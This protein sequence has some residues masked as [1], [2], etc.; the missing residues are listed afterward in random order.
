M[1]KQSGGFRIGD[2][3]RVKPGVM[4]PDFKGLSLAGWQGRVISIDEQDDDTL[5]GIQWDSVTL[6]AMPE[7]FIAQSEAEGCDCTEIGLGI[8]ELEPAQ[9]R[10]NAADAQRSARFVESNGFWMDMGEQGKRILG[11]IKGTDPD[12]PWEALEAW[13]EHLRKTLTFPFDATVSEFQ[14]HGPLA[15]GDKVQAL[16]I[17]KTDETMGVMIGIKG[18]WRKRRFP[19]CDL[20]VIPRKAPAYLPVNDYCVWFANR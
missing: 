12:D 1:A 2:S 11:V 13:E 3:V 8:E 17:E 15:E 4:C 5:V 16:S 20:E 18:G 6:A 7:N 10:D 14:E 19:L 9:A